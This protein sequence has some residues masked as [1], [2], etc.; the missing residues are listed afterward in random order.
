MGTK[1]GFICMLDAGRLSLI[2]TVVVEIPP[3]ISGSSCGCQ[4]SCG[5]LVPG[6]CG[7]KYLLEIV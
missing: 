3:G 5:I 7:G 6:F 1:L 2:V 4:Q